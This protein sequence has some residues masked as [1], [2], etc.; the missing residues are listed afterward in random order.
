MR[1]RFGEFTLD[2]RTGNLEGPDGPVNLRR[3]TFRLLEVLLANAP[4]L[5]DRNR[6]LDEAWGRRALSANVLPQAI[7]ELR[8]ALGDSSQSP[9]YIETL[10]RRGYRMVCAV[11]RLSESE[12]EAGEP[13]LAQASSQ[14]RIT[15]Q[16]VALST[17]LAMLLAV[18]GL[19]WYSD[20]QQHMLQDSVLPEV[21]ALLDQDLSLAWARLRQA[22]QR[23]PDDPQLEQ[24]WRDVTLPI[25]LKSDPPGAEIWARG[26]RTGPDDWVRLGTTPLDEVRLPLAML[27]FRVEKQGY[28]V[29]ENA[30]G[31]LPRAETFVLHPSDEV[32]NNMV[33]VPAGAVRLGQQRYDIPAFWIDRHE[34]TNR[35]FREFVID[36]GYGDTHWWSELIAHT[37]PEAFEERMRELVDKTGLPGPAS[38]AMG[39]Y[40]EN[41]GDHP[42]EG[43]SWF[44]AMAYAQWAGKQLPTVLHWRRAAGL[45]T[46]QTQNFADM[47]LT[48]QFNSNT[49]TAVGELD[50]IGPY[51]SQDMAGNVA[52]WCLNE[53]GD[54][55]HLAG[56]SW[57]EDRYRFQDLDARD[58]FSREPGMGFRLIQPIEPVPSD[59]TLELTLPNLEHPA[60][61]DDATFDAMRR[62]FDYDPVPLDART[63]LT[64]SSH[65]DW[66]REK[67]SFA[68]AYPGDRVTAWIYLPRVGQ[69]PYPTIVHYPGGDALLLTDSRQAG[70]HHIEPFLRSGHAVVYP[71]YLGTFE[72]RREE[73]SGTSTWRTLLVNQVRDLRRTLDYL[74]TRSD[75]DTDRMALHGVS[76]GGYRA[77]YVLAVED[78]FR[79]AILLSTG[80]IRADTLPP[81]AQL[82][83]YL[84][85]VTL[86]I[87]LING[88]EDFNFPHEQ[89]Q[90]PF[91]ELLGTPEAE[92]HHLVLDWG[93]LPPRY[94][95]VVRAYLAW[96]DQWLEPRQQTGEDLR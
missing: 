16:T 89:S 28:E 83:N 2:S 58:P 14:R 71:V 43:I 94:T 75:I 69:P 48:A 90:K 70:L 47:V 87:L 68:A 18:L 54:R 85:R 82:H 95:E 4:E 65:Q 34:V 27:R 81:D 25:P 61:V 74:E 33:H 11:E 55:R 12:P 39:T 72:R 26:Y 13:T 20:N 92:K 36:G 42:V 37:G 64:D 57:I 31:F 45:G 84:P 59:L 3:Q 60:P 80:L 44:E 73:L 5:L 38:W 63:E 56:G 1:Y 62:Q 10:H 77:P 51:G 66:Q 50:A 52:E 49:T 67:I 23:W 17:S 79:T 8:Q 53:A 91:F 9:D 76:Y 21:R 86:P 32:P 22:R 40:A 93:H 46:D 41:Q 78:R 88:R 24:L 30:P 7:S 6:L 19:W 96:T 35:E 29:L 15:P